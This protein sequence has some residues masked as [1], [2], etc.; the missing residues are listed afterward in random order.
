MYKVQVSVPAT[1]TN[2][3]PGLDV[4]GLALSLHVSVELLVR[5]DDE[6]V[7][8]VDGEGAELIP[9]NFDNVALRAA[10]RVFQHF[11]RAPAGLQLTI[12]NAIPWDVGLGA[13]N[14]MIIGGIVAAHNLVEGNFNR[15]DLLHF[16]M[17]Q[18]VKPT[19]AIAAMNG[20]LSICSQLPDG[21]VAYRSQDIV[22]L[23]V[24]VV[25]PDLPE[26]H[27][28]QIGFPGLVAFEDAIFNIGQT[29][30][31]V[32]AL[33]TGDFDLL[34]QSLGDKLHQPHYIG[35]IPGFK[36]VSEVALEEGAIGMVLSG[37]GPSVLVIAENYHEAIADAV[38]AAFAD[39][40]VE[41]QAWVVGVDRQGMLISVVE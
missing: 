36:V 24:V 1:S 29:A 32:E 10:M 5:D 33:R 38:Q 30:L 11:E 16:A 15:A 13:E 26:Y 41:S 25:L 12:D 28:A 40:G 17:Q 7:V 34:A 22:P 37:K 23:R 18:G 3:G 21:G 20:G 9:E 4:L 6:L 35:Y 2:L 14:A 31:A 39:S 19:A 8:I 27:G